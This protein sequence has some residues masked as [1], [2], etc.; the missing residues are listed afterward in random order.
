MKTKTSKWDYMKLKSQCVAKE[1]ISK[2]KR[3]PIAWK[4][5]FSND[6]SDKGLI[7]NVQRTY[8]TQHFKQPIT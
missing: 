1:V 5:I 2:M 4:M 7:L 6:I 3:P 8:A